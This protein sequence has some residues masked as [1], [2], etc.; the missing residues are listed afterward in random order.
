MSTYL[1]SSKGIMTKLKIKHK[2]KPMSRFEIFLN[3]WRRIYKKCDMGDLG[4]CR[5]YFEIEM[6]KR[7]PD[8]F[9]S[10]DSIKVLSQPITK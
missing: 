6:K 3:K 5:D 2:H 8:K 4:D 9:D 1:V 10:I 7:F